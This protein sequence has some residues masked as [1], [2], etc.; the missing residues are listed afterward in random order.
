[1]DLD[2]QQLTRVSTSRSGQSR[3]LPNAR[4]FLG[5]YAKSPGSTRSS[6]VQA[7]CQI[8]VVRILC[9]MRGANLEIIGEYKSRTSGGGSTSAMRPETPPIRY[10]ASLR[11]EVDLIH[12]E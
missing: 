4:W 12:Q 10:F 9:L 1:M 3:L 8:R 2:E 6:K 11:K 5:P 7:Y